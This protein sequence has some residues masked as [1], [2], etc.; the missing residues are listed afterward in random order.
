MKS[1]IT[2]SALA[3]A[4]LLSLGGVVASQASAQS[5]PADDNSMS[6]NQPV[7]DSWI[8]TKVKTEL[9]STGGVK[10]TDVSVTTVNGVVTLTG[11]LASDLAVQKAVA[12]TQ[13]VR[14]VKKVDAS[15]LKSKD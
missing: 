8:T 3:L 4:T 7:S 9:A 1:S 15:G 6:S 11:V 2:L 12:A 13:S 5:A 10:S 14:G